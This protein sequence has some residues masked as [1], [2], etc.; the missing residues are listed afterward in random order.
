M[1][2]RQ[3]MTS[4]VRPNPDVSAT[5]LPRIMRPQRALP[6]DAV[7]PT[8]AEVNLA[9][10]RHNLRVV[11]RAANGRPVWAVLKADGYGHGAKGVART[12]ER[13]GASGICVALLE[14]GIELR[15]AGIR[16]PILV[17]GGYFGRAWSE[18]VRHDLTPVLHDLGQ[19]EALAEEVRFSETGTVKAHVKIDTG[20]SRLG[21]NPADI[22]RLAKTLTAHPEVR[23][24]GLM[25]HFASADSDDLESMNTQL[26]RFDAATETLKGHGHVA[27]ARHAANSAALLR[28]PRA[29]LD[30]VRPGIA[31]FGV[32]PR[33]GMCKG[34]RSVMR[35]RSEI[36]AL[37][38]VPVGGTVGYGATWKA[39]R[40]SRIA[41]VP[42]GYADGLVR[43][44]SN[45]GA[46]LVRGKRAPIVGAVSMDMTMIDVTDV[47]GAAIG[48][49]CCALGPQ[50]GPLGEDAI[51]ADE[52][53]RELGTIPWE[54]LTNVSRR[55]PR[56]YRE[57]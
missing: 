25:T 39:T 37:R 19:V 13:A 32:E 28:C 54:I 27:S 55:V 40:P 15:E 48:D 8:R 34:L 22:E 24:D 43:A 36:I 26:D 47:G 49:E 45:R 6:A 46:I 3:T 29:L 20:M 9:N 33:E 56:F 57:P 41:T 17:T 53:A 52:L 18:V 42:I 16:I 30:L 21:V 12:L 51:T 1:P 4:V 23:L 38:E 5:P 44:L 2:P 11:E 14:E 35:V 31:L 10:L 50:K 7:R